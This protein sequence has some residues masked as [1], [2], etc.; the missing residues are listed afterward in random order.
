MTDMDDARRVTAVV[1]RVWG[2][3]ELRPSLA[4]AFEHAGCGV[5]G[6]VGPD[7]ELVG[8]VLGFLGWQEGLHLHSHMLAVLPEWRSRGIG[9]ALKLAQRAA[10]LDAAVEEVRWT[11]DPLVVRN[12]RFNLVRL[13]TVGTAFL[14]GFYG[15]MTDRINRDDRSDRFEV[16]W[17]LL[18]ERVQQTLSG[19]SLPPPP[20]PVLLACDGDEEAPR[21]KET[22]A[23]AQPGAMIAVPADHAALRRRDPAL[24]SEWR[25]ASAR[26]FQSCFRAG[27]VV[28]WIT[29]AGEY[30]FVP[31][32]EALA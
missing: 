3:D 7:G 25:E 30:V 19:R 5:Y 24:G 27:L 20:G 22:A 14:P 16:R 9:Y 11:F 1:A 18:S 4:R 12:G 13:G 31:A 32:D 28:A 29:E 23:A 17:P 6:A 10:C 8:F 15:E 26:A 2:E 21:P